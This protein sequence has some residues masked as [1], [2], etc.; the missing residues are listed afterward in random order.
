MLKQALI[1]A[2]DVPWD[3]LGYLTG[4][5][6]FGG[7]VT[8][9]WDRR[10]VRSILSKYY[11]PEVLL[12]GYKF[13]PS[14]IYFAPPDGLLSHA[15]A[16][17]ESLP[18]TDEPE[19]FGMHENANVSYQ[20][21][22]SRRLTRI[23]LD[24]QSRVAQS[25]DALS[26]EELAAKLAKRILDDWPPNLVI[27]TSGKD[28]VQTHIFKVDAEGRMLNALST[29]LAQEVVR[30]NKLLNKV[31]GSL[32]TLL[33]AVKGLVVMNSELELV[34]KSLMNN[35]VPASWAVA[36]YPSLKSLV[37]W[38]EDLH[39]RIK[40]MHRW[41]TEGEPKAFWLPGF[42]FPQGFLTGVLQ[43]HAR[44]FNLPIDTLNFSHHMLPYT[45]DAIPEAE[46]K[47]TGVIVKGIF[48]EGA[49]WDSTK[50]TLEDALPMEMCSVCPLS[51]CVQICL[52]H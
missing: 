12:E 16:Y 38:V 41:L 48:L 9:E 17:V 34:F 27:D 51:L 46:S 23:V 11:R 8:D 39:A 13:S 37:V 22:E 4:E 18:M 29:V 42:F 14:G 25:G 10:T 43:N 28:P 49:R 21:Q 2:D 36:A 7:R 47:S 6:T 45:E 26:P 33:K 40:M 30:Y 24:V 31:R 1:E 52:V 3:A 35:E 44:K 20:L 19:V 5:I 50:Q 15:R 32:T